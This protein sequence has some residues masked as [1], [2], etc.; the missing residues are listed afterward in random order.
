MILNRAMPRH[1]KQYLNQHL[2]VLSLL[3]E[4]TR[5]QAILPTLTLPRRR[6]RQPRLTKP[7]PR[8]VQRPP[9]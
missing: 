7:W 3:L 1:L 4:A 8:R 6:A 5:P 9:Y 2:K